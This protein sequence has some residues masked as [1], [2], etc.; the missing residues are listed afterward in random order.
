M[1]WES[2][3]NWRSSLP[4][5]ARVPMRGQRSLKLVDDGRSVRCLADT[6]LG[7]Q[8]A[9][10]QPAA[11][12]RHRWPFADASGAVLSRE[13]RL[14]RA[15]HIET[16]SNGD[17]VGFSMLILSYSSPKGLTGHQQT[18]ACRDRSRSS[19][20]W[21]RARAESVSRRVVRNPGPRP[22][23]RRAGLPGESPEAGRACSVDSNTTARS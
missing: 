6:C 8:L 20:G 22:W 23:P 4:L 5:Q 18:D 3:S 10:G 21:G 12:A 2:L 7:S 14:G 15:R 1:S 13:R 11:L 19:V 17:T 9:Q 16:V